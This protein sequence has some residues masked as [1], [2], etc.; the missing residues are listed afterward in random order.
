MKKGHVNKIVG[1]LVAFTLVLA[2][3]N[4]SYAAPITVT[5]TRTSSLTNVDDSAGRWQFDGGEVRSAGTLV[6][7]YARTKRVIFGG[8][9]DVQNTAMLTITIFVLGADPPENVTLQGSHSF[10]T[11]GIKGSVS[12]TSP[13]FPVPGAQGVT[14][15][16]D[17]TALTFDLP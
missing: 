1:I 17:D 10:N 9:T 14:F 13:G 11:G 4:T 6:A 2:C 16:G 12:A 7:H 3:S 15:H 8:G 5:L